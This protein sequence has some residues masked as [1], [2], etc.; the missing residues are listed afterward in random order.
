MSERTI[1]GLDQTEL[2]KPLIEVSKQFIQE[3]P[4]KTEGESYDFLSKNVKEVFK[5]ESFPDNYQ[6]DVKWWG[7]ISRTELG[8]ELPDGTK[9][10]LT[11]DIDL[12]NECSLSCPHCFRRTENADKK[13]L[14]GWLSDAEVTDYIMAAK[15]LGLKQIKIL[16]RGE[17]FQ[18][19]NFLSFLRK[20]TKEEIGVSVFTKGHVIGSDKLINTYYGEQFKTD[21]NLTETSEMIKT[22]ADLVEELKKLNVSILLGFNSFDQAMQEEFVGTRENEQALIKKEY[23]SYRDRALTLLAQAGFN[24]YHDGQATRLAMIAAPVKPENIDQIFDLY[25]WARTR[26]IYMLTCPTTETTR[27]V[28]EEGQMEKDRQKKFKEFPQKVED[29]WVN[30]YKWAVE[31]KLIPLRRFLDDGASLYP[32]CHVCNQTAAGFYLNLS[33]QVNQCPGR[34]DTDTVFTDDIRNIN[35]EETEVIKIMNDEDVQKNKISKENEEY[36]LAK[37]TAQ[38]KKVWVNS[39]NYKRAEGRGYNYRC[40]ARDGHSLKA[41]FYRRVEGRVIKSIL[42]SQLDNYFKTIT[43]TLNQLESQKDIIQMNEGNIQ[44]LKNYQNE[45]MLIKEAISGMM[46]ER[47]A[48]RDEMVGILGGINDQADAIK[49]L[50]NDFGDKKEIDQKLSKVVE[51]FKSGVDGVMRLIKDI[52]QERTIRRIYPTPV[53]DDFVGPNN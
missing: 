17:P 26:N 49:W 52:T 16:G 27:E 12:G 33:G 24:E 4:V 23:V 18:N 36:R 6:N 30:I 47:A 1:P 39:V 7:N 28:N 20:M 32:G 46:D 14:N 10:I 21:D 8:S 9:K 15:K 35:T 53:I 2:I 29:L 22:G 25:R 13:P 48:S 45:I 51:E 42:G 34:F 3:E 44:R 37:K 43:K 50:L 19:P 5:E 31:K 38:L 41:G 11:M 40:A